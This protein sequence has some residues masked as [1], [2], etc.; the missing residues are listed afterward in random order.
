[1]LKLCCQ[2]DNNHMALDASTMPRLATPK[3]RKVDASKPASGDALDENATS[4]AQQ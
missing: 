1:M 3:K 4:I 2:T